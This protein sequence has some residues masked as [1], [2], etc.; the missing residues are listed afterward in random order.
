MHDSFS[1]ILFIH[2]FRALRTVGIAKHFIVR[3]DISESNSGSN[4]VLQMAYLKAW[5]KR[6]AEM[7]QFLHSDSDDD[8]E[9]QRSVKDRSIC[10]LHNQADSANSFECIYSATESSTTDESDF[11]TDE[12]NASSDSE[13][14][15]LNDDAEL[16]VPDLEENLRQWFTKNKTTQRSLNEL[17]TILRKQ[18]HL[19]PKDARTLLATPRAV[20]SEPKC[21]GQY[22]YYGLEKGNCH[23]LTQTM[24]FRHDHDSINLSI[25]IDGVQ[26]WP[27]LAKFHN[28]EPF[29][30][31]LFC[32]DK[33]P[34]PRRIS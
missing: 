15:V 21:G 9:S 5:R 18:G 31:A 4:Y 12:E 25:N 13:K 8:H 26:F 22:I 23:L 30:V 2:R 16:D 6:K 14:E 10:G 29:V 7:D 11:D 27:I 3:K 24:T 34:Y 1:D 17:L 28:F 33:K 20:G 32:G 19:L